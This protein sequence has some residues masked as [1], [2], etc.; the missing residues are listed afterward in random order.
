MSEKPELIS[1]SLCPFVQRSVIT[2]LHKNV[3]FDIT[4]IDLDNRPSW[5]QEISPRGKVPLLK[6]KGKVLFESAVINEYLDE[7]FGESMHPSDPLQRALDR[8]WI[9]FASGLIGTQFQAY[10]AKD[11]AIFDEKLTTLEAGLVQLSATQV[12]PYFHGKALSLVDT[13][14]APVLMRQALL[15]KKLNRPWPTEL[16]SCE[17]WWNALAAL[18]AV[19]NSVR[20]TFDEELVTYFQKRDAWL[21][22]SAE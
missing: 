3:D 17:Q 15:Y 16:A 11:K 2:L 21:Y 13:A 19:T 8:A 10:L 9:E 4:Y 22:R 6:T 7:S 20:E 1:F 5:F 14:V 18:P 12:G